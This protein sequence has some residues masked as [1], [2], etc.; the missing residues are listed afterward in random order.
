[1]RKTLFTLVI[2]FITGYGMVKVQGQQ[3]ISTAG[4][5]FKNASGSLSWTLGE[6]VIKTVE[7]SDLIL[8]Q[9]FQQTMLTVTGVKILP[10]YEPDVSA[11]P[12]P[13]TDIVSIQLGSILQPGNWQ[14]MLYDLNGK[15]I[16]REKFQSNAANVSLA[17]F[18][19]ATYF[20]KVNKAG[21]ESKIFKI[22]KR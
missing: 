2:I 20:L 4:T 15:M 14:Y 7:N 6:P 5:Q 19:D 13:T 12:N 21:Q 10:G 8:T 16:L 11:Y 22:V 3:V 1:M 18:P 9:G 17:S